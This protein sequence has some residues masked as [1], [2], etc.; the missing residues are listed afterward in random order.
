MTNQQNI[1]KT[2]TGILE[3][4]KQPGNVSHACRV[5]GYSR[6]S[7]YRLKTLCETGGEAATAEIS[8]QKLNEKNRADWTCPH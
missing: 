1:I 6:D 7:F 3:P 4:A 2:K 8:R 5:A